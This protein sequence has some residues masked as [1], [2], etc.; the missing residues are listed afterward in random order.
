MFSTIWPKNFFGVKSHMGTPLDSI[1][2]PHIFFF[3]YRS[4][5]IWPYRWFFFSVRS[6]T[7][8]YD[9]IWPKNFNFC[10]KSYGKKTRFNFFFR[11]KFTKFHLAL[12]KVMKNHSK[13]FKELSALF[14]IIWLKNFFLSKVIWE[15]Y[16]IEVFLHTI[17]FFWVKFTKF[18]LAP[19]KVMKNH[20][21]L[22]KDYPHYFSSYGWRNF[23]VS[24]FLWEYHLIQIL[25]HTQ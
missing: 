16:S 3:S 14:F 6:K 10:Q 5:H 19:K 18:H 15:H 13:L 20:S 25:V 1:F 22:F 2:F 9:S 24:K 12:K 8:L 21:K 4:G 11:A 23:W 7:L 17:F